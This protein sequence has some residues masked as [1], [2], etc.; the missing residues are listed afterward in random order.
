VPP[1][2]KIGYTRIDYKEMVG[3]VVQRTNRMSADERALIFV[4]PWGYKEIDPAELKSLL[5]NTKTEL[6]LFLP[7]YFMSRFANKSKNDLEYKGGQALRKFMGKLFNGLENVPHVKNQKNFIYLVQEQFRS[8]LNIKYV[9][10]FKIERD[11]DNNWFCIFFFTHNKKGF[12]K[13]LEAKWSIDRK[14]GAEFKIGDN[15]KSEM[16]DEMEINAYD[17][18]VLNLLLQNKCLTNHDLLDFG[19]SNNFLPKHTKAVLDE[20]KK[21]RH[22][23]I[24]PLDGK[25]ALGYYIGSDER[26][27][28]IKIV[29]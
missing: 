11:N 8:Y 18:K 5:E 9:D 29:G 26:L 24:A 27:V 14:R 23:E 12:Q 17:E 1:N 4:D 7:I 25:P 28:N 15:I 16:F 19:L 2:V 10:S 21:R 20:L 22:I 6:I 3:K 13:M